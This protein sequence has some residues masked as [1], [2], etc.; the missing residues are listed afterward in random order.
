MKS[1]RDYVKK[2][3]EDWLL[4]KELYE[5]TLGIRDWEERVRGS[6]TAREDAGDTSDAEEYSDYVHSIAPIVNSWVD[7]AHSM[8]FGGPE[9]C[10]VRPVGRHAD[11]TIA[12]QLTKLLGE[13]LEELDIESRVYDLLQ[14]KAVYGTSVSKQAWYWRS[15]S[16]RKHVDPLTDETFNLETPSW[17]EG[18]L[19]QLVP[20]ERFLP[21]WRATHLDVQRWRGV[22]HRVEKTY[23]EIILGF[24]RGLYDLGEDEFKEKFQRTDGG[25]NAPDEYAQTG[26]TDGYV[27]SDPHGW[28]QLWEWHGQASTPAGSY[29]VVVVVATER[30]SDDPTNGV[31][32][33][34]SDG[35]AIVLGNRRL[36][37]FAVDHYF[38]RPEPFGDGLVNSNRD[39]LHT[40]SRLIG[41]YLDNLQYILS[42]G[43][44]VDPESPAGRELKQLGGKRPPG[45]TPPVMEGTK[46]FTELPR[47]D[48]P[49]NENLSAVQFF[50]QMLERRGTTNT[51]QG[52]TS[53]SR[54]S[55][56]EINTLFQQS[57]VPTEVRVRLFCKNLLNKALTQCLELIRAFSDE[58]AVLWEAQPAGW[59]PTVIPSQAMQGP[60]EYRAYAAVTKQ[61]A[62]S[63]VKASTLQQLLGQIEML[64]MGLQQQGMQ[65]NLAEL[66][67]KLFHLLKLDDVDKLVIPVP[68]PP[69][70]PMQGPGQP[71]QGPPP[72]QMP[73]QNGTPQGPP[74]DNN[75]MALQMQ[76]Q[77]SRGVE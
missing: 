25:S 40:L 20:L 19:T 55:A 13:R 39:T 57:Q 7:N 36:R 45:W 54:Q 56:T 16:P 71:M 3:E 37:P 17:N 58:D 30:T 11:G 52:L 76:M 22:G 15:D 74:T 23:D 63:Q 32:L 49:T 73:G 60:A 6:S 12:L 50:E 61:D 4:C 44:G 14:Q 53:E 51:F 21:D 70:M 34:V 10:L 33:R 77:A 5:G 67:M 1:A 68:P 29:E 8:I 64:Q 65:L 47:A 28:V 38:Q 46:P 69:P 43:M 31:V 18:P 42:G 27:E 2:K 62:T 24:Q 26:D 66:V 72:E 75:L 9:W 35:P 41:M 48:Y 59:E